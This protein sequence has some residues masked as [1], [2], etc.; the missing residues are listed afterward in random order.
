MGSLRQIPRLHAVLLTA[1]VLGA[2]N[3]YV[4]DSPVSIGIDRDGGELSIE[5]AAGDDALRLPAGSL[6][7]YPATSLH[8]VNE[9]TRAGVEVEELDI[10]RGRIIEPRL[11]ATAAGTI[12]AGSGRVDI[13]SA[14]VL[15][16]SLSLRTGGL[17]ILPPAAGRPAANPERPYM[18]TPVAGR[19][20]AQGPL[21]PSAP[22]VH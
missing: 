14:E 12:D 22:Q 1:I 20:P 11:V 4:L 7:A 13:S 8:H 6:V 2:A 3:F 15:T 16:A 5:S 21:S 19:P 17:A 18:P 10:D 9:V